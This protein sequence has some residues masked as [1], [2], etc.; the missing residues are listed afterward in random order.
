MGRDGAMQGIVERARMPGSGQRGRNEKNG[1]S[2]EFFHGGGRS[3]SYLASVQAPDGWRQS[4][5]PIPLKTCGGWHC[6]AFPAPMP[7]GFDSH[8]N[9]AP[10]L[11]PVGVRGSNASWNKTVYISADGKFY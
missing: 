3:Q 2:D 7:T 5:C 4:R 11:V 9:L 1:G 8:A 6:T 10:N